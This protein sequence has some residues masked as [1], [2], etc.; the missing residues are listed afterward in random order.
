VFFCCCRLSASGQA[1]FGSSSR[2]PPITHTR[3][4]SEFER[5]V[6]DFLQKKEAKEAAAKAIRRPPIP[7][8]ANRR[9]H[10]AAAERVGTAAITA[11]MDGG[12]VE[13]E[14]EEIV[15]SEIDGSA[16]S[17][18]DVSTLKRKKVCA[19]FIK[20]TVSRDFRPLVVFHQSI[21]LGSLINRLNDFCIW[22]RI[23]RAIRK[24]K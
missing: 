15:K 6:T 14:E 10:A 4:L 2:R 13:E 3:L 21:P 19:I 18:I 20:E 9:K 17:I 1:R 23:R 11:L 7:A 5:S 22:L 16:T 8:A 12:I 24:Y